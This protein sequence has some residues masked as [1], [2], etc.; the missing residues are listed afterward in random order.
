MIGSR[1]QICWS[2]GTSGLGSTLAERRMALR[3][4]REAALSDE[5]AAAHD[6]VATLPS[7]A[8]VLATTSPAE[9]EEA[10][11][12]EVA[13]PEAGD[14]DSEDDLDEDAVSDFYARRPG[15]RVM[16]PCSRASSSRARG[17][18]THRV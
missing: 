2:G 7:V 10:A 14:D 8:R 11:V 13:D 9:D 6:E 18:G 16:A 4:S 5:E 1:S 15:R 12:I 17:M 3:L